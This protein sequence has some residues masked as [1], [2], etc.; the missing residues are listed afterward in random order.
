M[1][2]LAALD[3]DLRALRGRV[4]SLGSG[5]GVLERYLA[6]INPHVDV[7][8]LELDKERVRIAEA[9]APARVRIRQAD[10]TKLA[11]EGEYDAAL[12]VD[13]LHHIPYAQQPA[14]LAALAGQ[15]RPG[16]VCIV[17][18]ISTEPHWKHEWNRL[19]DRL[20][21]GEDV[22]C[23]SPQEM[24]RLLEEAGMRGGQARSVARLSPYPHYLASARR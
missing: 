13:V 20:V 10:V 11:G 6:E 17:K 7:H 2:P 5:H 3:R 24:A 8:G 15:L 18:D 16:G 22:H 21:A 12:A 14:V 19:H 1:L 9:S 23:R 4:L